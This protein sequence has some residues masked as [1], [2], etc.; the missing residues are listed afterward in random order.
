VLRNEAEILGSAGELVSALKMFNQCVLPLCQCAQLVG[1]HVLRNTNLLIFS[2]LEALGVWRLSVLTDVGWGLFCILYIQPLEYIQPT[3]GRRHYSWLR[4]RKRFFV[5]RLLSGMSPKSFWSC[6]YGHATG[7]YFF[8]LAM[9]FTGTTVPGS[10]PWKTNRYS[11]RHEL[12]PSLLFDCAT[13]TIDACMHYCLLPSACNW[14]VASLWHNLPH[15]DCSFSRGTMWSPYRM[16][17][18]AAKRQGCDISQAPS[19]PPTILDSSTQQQYRKKA[20]LQ[21]VFQ[22]PKI[23]NAYCAH[24]PTH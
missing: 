24:S 18:V 17:S 23:D 14:I 12:S 5:P 19:F 9:K 13:E 7:V 10:D 20:F 1:L 2:S 22:P 6:N 3:S 15:T 8:L 16:R 4:C 11:I 21:Q